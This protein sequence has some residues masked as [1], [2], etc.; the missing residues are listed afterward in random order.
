MAILENGDS[1]VLG[2]W[3]VLGCL[4]LYCFS[5]MV[6]QVSHCIIKMIHNTRFRNI[7]NNNVIVN[8]EREPFVG[9]VDSVTLP[10]TD[11]SLNVQCGICFEEDNVSNMRKTIG[12]GH[13]FHQDCLGKWIIE[14]QNQMFHW[15]T[16]TCPTCRSL[17]YSHIINKNI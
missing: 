7:H 2:L 4:L 9:N 1:S 16:W 14:L 6:F 13:Y 15:K 11:F 8:S 10:L 17:L 12:C 5:Y 3:I